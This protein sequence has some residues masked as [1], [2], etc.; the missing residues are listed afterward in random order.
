MRESECRSHYQG[1]YERRTRTLTPPD[2]RLKASIPDTSVSQFV[3]TFGKNLAGSKKGIAA[4]L[5]RKWEKG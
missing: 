2:K 3:T 5:S 1:F 4:H